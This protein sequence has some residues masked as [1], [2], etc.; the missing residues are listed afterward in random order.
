MAGNQKPASNK[1][2]QVAINNA[3]ALVMGAE[4]SPPK[5]RLRRLAQYTR[6]FYGPMRQTLLEEELLRPV[7][8]VV[9]LLSCALLTH[10]A[11]TAEADRKVPAVE[12]LDMFFK[13]DE[14]PGHARL[15]KG[16]DAR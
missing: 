14:N 15:E 12:I 5:D 11:T 3:I 2:I 16:E 7:E 13:E 10:A 1:D 9:I 6:A 8:A 4:D